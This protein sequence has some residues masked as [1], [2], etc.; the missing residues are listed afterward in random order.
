MVLAIHDLV[1]SQIV[2]IRRDCVFVYV[3]TNN[4][5]ITSYQRRCNFMTSFLTSCACWRGGFALLLLLL[6]TWPLLFCVCV[7]DSLT[8]PV[9]G[10]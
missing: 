6:F 7:C 1:I 5:E 10:L 8:M 2:M 4:L 9:V 3:W